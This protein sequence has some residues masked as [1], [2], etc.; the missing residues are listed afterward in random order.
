METTPGGRVIVPQPQIPKTFGILNLIFGGLLL[1]YGLGEAVVVVAMPYLMSMGQESLQ[2]VQTQEKAKRQAEIAELKE[3]EATAKTAAEKTKIAAERRARESLP[4][5]DMT[6]I[7]TDVQELQGRARVIQWP[8]IGSG[9]LLNALMI[10]SGAGLIGLKEW[11]RKLVLGVAGF[12]VLRLV[13]L[14]TATLLFLPTQM[15]QTQAMLARMEAQMNRAA[16]KTSPNP[17]SLSNAV[18]AGAEKA[19]AAAKAS[20]KPA[21]LAEVFQAAF[22]SAREKGR[23][24]AKAS[25]KP[26]SLSNAVQAGEGKAKAAAKA[27]PNPSATATDTAVSPTGTTATV[28]PRVA[29]APMPGFAKEAALFGMIWGTIWAAGFFVL[30]VIYPLLTIWFL[31][32]PGAWAACT[33][34]AR[35]D[36]SGF[37]GS[38]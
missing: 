14:T 10:V 17:A 12:K 1:L 24:I 19:K 35:L 15:K 34:R 6:P 16:A 29:V 9:L 21:S 37:P 23:A 28:A 8:Q 30:A 20:P 26:A 3:R 36:A 22:D 2:Q 11:A 31:T 25:R 5:P 18:Q 32:R 38:P 4:E 13:A 33:A 27:S 7:F